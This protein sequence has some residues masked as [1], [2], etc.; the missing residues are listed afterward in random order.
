[1]MRP[2]TPPRAREALSDAFCAPL[3]ALPE[4]APMV[5]ERVW[6]TASP[7]VPLLAPSEPKARP[8]P[9]RG[10]GRGGSKGDL[11]C[12]FGAPRGGF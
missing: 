1:M 5:K 10:Q 4:K 6:L 2:H 3:G 11:R 9:L 8:Q 12:P 7:L